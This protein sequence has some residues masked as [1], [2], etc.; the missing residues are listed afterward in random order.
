MP[1]PSK[2][3][4]HLRLQ[5]N[6]YTTGTYFVTLCTR[7]RRE[8]FGRVIGSGAN[9][10]LEPNELGRIVVADWNALPGYFPHLRLDQFQLMP[11]HMHGIL[12]LDGTASGSTLRVDAAGAVDNVGATPRGP[13]PGSQGAII[14]AFKS[15][16]TYRMNAL[17]GTPGQRYWQ[18]GYHERYIRR[19]AGEF[20]RIAAYIEQNPAKWR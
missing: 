8:W 9:A 1:N 16:T 3:H 12:V 18:L 10:I 20:E 5:G 7:M 4:K 17:N 13:V 19:N 2:Y 11:D 15:G 6:D 14:G